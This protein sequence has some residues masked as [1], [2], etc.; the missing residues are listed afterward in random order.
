MEPDGVFGLPLAD[1]LQYEGNYSFHAIATY[2][3]NCTGTR[4]LTWTIHVETGIDSSN[5]DIRTSVIG[6]LPDGKNYVRID[7]TPKDKYGNLLGPGRLDAF[8]V[9]GTTNSTPQGS[10][11]D[12]GDG[13]YSV[14]V[15]ND[16]SAA[17]PPAIVISQEERNPVIVAPPEAQDCKKWKQRFWWL[18]LLL[19]LLLVLVIIWLVS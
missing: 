7:F 13:S 12:T 19:L 4:E 18:L 16:P 2:G 10:V 1:L 3:E 11:S 5:T 15:V 14:V 9:S 6:S 17:N 8:T